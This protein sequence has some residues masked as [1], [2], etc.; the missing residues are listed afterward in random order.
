MVSSKAAE[1]VYQLLDIRVRKS[2]RH[3]WENKFDPALE[4]GEAG[5]H[6]HSNRKDPHYCA[7]VQYTMKTLMMNCMTTLHAPS[8]RAAIY[9]QLASARHHPRGNLRK[10]AG[11]GIHSDPQDMIRWRIEGSTPLGPRAGQPRQAH[12][13]CSVLARKLNDFTSTQQHF[14]CRVP[15]IGTI[16]LSP[17]YDDLWDRQ[18]S[19]QT[20]ESGCWA[21]EFHHMLVSV[22][23]NI[24]VLIRQ[25]SFRASMSSHLSGRIRRKIECSL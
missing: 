1:V 17:V 5:R 20:V 25:G 19:G 14:S 22:S 7:R 6:R 21:P 8:L 23:G 24:G 12:H 4:R 15:F 16:S 3:N 10:D 2:F 11:R 18:T 13:E 9:C